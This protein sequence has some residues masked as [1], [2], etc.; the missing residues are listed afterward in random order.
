MMLAQSVATGT[1]V[2]PNPGGSL[3]V[4]DWPKRARGAY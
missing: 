4:C 1:M 2:R 3:A